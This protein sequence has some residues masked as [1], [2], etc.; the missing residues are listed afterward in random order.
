MVKNTI[1][2]LL[3]IMHT[4]PDNITTIGDNDELVQNPCNYLI[5]VVI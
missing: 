5:V 4:T 2:E 1:H 3:K